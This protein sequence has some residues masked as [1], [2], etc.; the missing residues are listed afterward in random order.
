MEASAKGITPIEVMLDNMRFFYNE[1]RDLSE[2]LSKLPRPLLDSVPQLNELLGKVLQARE[3]AEDAA[4]DAAPYIHPRLATISH[5]LLNPPD[6]RDP[7]Q[8]TD[9]QLL[10]I[11]QG[12]GGE[13]A[14]EAA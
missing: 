14:P 11:I 6:E 12:D 4:V 9:Q 5:E 8:L 1:L 2:Q 7:A 13:G 3:L 10:A